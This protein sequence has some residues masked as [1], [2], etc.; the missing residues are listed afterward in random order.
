MTAQINSMAELRLIVTSKLHDA[1]LELSEGQ[2]HPIVPRISSS[3]GRNESDAFVHFAESIPFPA[4]ISATTQ[5]EI[6]KTEHARIV[7]SLLD[8][9]E[10]VE[11]ERLAFCQEGVFD[12]I[13]N[14]SRQSLTDGR[15]NETPDEVANLRLENSR[16][17][18]KLQDKERE[19]A[20]ALVRLRA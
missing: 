3:S 18:D 16:L 19:L 5:P 12:L 17:R 7:G 8:R 20:E 11:T 13:K 4:D 2:R 14:L 9:I 10:K 1:F 6:S 15:P